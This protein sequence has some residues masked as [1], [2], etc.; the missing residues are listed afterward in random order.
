[1]F[2]IVLQGIAY[3]QEPIINTNKSEAGRMGR[4]GRIVYQTYVIDKDFPPVYDDNGKLKPDKPKLGNFFFGIEEKDGRVQLGKYSEVDDKFTHTL[5]W[6]DVE[7]LLTSTEPITVGYAVEQGFLESKIRTNAETNFSEDNHLNLRVVSRPEMKMAPARVPGEKLSSSQF[8]FTWY[9]VFDVEKVEGKLYYL[10]GNTR[11]LFTD[12]YMQSTDS[13]EAEKSLLGWIEQIKVKEWCSNIVYEYN[14]EKDAVDDRYAPGSRGKSTDK[15]KPAVVYATQEENEKIMGIEHIEE[16]WTPFYTGK[17]ENLMAA[18]DPRGL[19]PEIPRFHILEKDGD[20]YRIATLGSLKNQKMSVGKIGTLMKKLTEANEKLRAVDI[21]F[22]VD[23]TGSMGTE[24]NAVSK[25]LQEICNAFLKK[26][27]SANSVVTINSG[28]RKIEFSIEMDINI[29]LVVY[30]DIGAN[31]EE[32]PFNTKV[33][34]AGKPLTENIADIVGGFSKLT[35]MLSGGNEALHDGLMT[36]L[37][38]GNIWRG[39][40]SNRII[41]VIADEPGDSG[42]PEQQVVLDKMPFPKGLDKQSN[43]DQDEFKKGETLIYGLYTNSDGF[44]VF[45]NNLRLVT[46]VDQRLFHLP[47][48]ESDR[49]QDNDLIN[50]L[51]DQ[52]TTAE[53]MVEK[54]LKDLTK[55]ITDQRN[56]EPEATDSIVAV[57]LREAAIDRILK[58]TG[59]SENDLST[60][61]SIAFTEGYIREQQNNHKY[62]TFRQRVT[63]THSDVNNLQTISEQLS[64]GLYK[65]LESKDIFLKA[66]P[67]FV[68][69]KA[70]V[71]AVAEASNVTSID[72]PEKL[73]E[74]AK[75]LI[76]KLEGSEQNTLRDILQ[77]KNSLP[78]DDDGLL[79]MPGD[80]LLKLKYEELQDHAL[81]L[82][83][84]SKCLRNIINGEDAPEEF[85]KVDEHKEQN[86]HWSHRH[87]QSGVEFYYVPKQY[88]P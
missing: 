23:G 45:K 43:I 38:H 62:K 83:R 37:N 65:A 79:G 75:E 82:K 39:D 58:E 30:Q 76:K 52:V 87:P 24:I 68:I 16:L 72:T 34:F 69:A 59:I 53:K 71:L 4:I 88:L 66:D 50:I 85:N 36:A 12:P 15:R 35:S 70:L 44:D 14:T 67:K 28:G 11:E 55:K 61:G 46:D 78:V 64:T 31:N 26:M 54:R 51:Y 74:S 1:M 9:Y 3:G 8:Q 29:S 56:S 49:S 63:L 81:W 80:K 25:F 6:V 77:V 48:F 19:D 41:L 27:K 32:T 42:D 73:N 47:Q 10:V 86:K 17:E 7:N 33:I 60:L 13:S 20:W 22:V 57:L 5:G 84:K 2:L 18:H 40:S 21:A